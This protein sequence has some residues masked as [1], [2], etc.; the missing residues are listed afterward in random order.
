MVHP[1][2]KLRA[3]ALREIDLAPDAQALDAARVKYLGR[4][5]SISG[6]GER[7][8]MVDPQERPIVGKLLNEVR[9]AVTVAIAERAEKFR[10]QKE[11]D[12]LAKID[13]SL[14]GTP[15]ESGSLHPLTQ[16]LDRPIQ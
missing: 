12:A 11:S 7:V 1:L 16:M 14:P 9:N 10:A 8:K 3:E 4:S 5:G 15:S 6:W 13:I 2:Q